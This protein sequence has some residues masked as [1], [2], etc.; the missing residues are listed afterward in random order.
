MSDTQKQP[1]GNTQLPAGIPPPSPAAAAPTSGPGVRT[2]TYT[3]AELADKIRK[4]LAEQVREA[5]EAARPKEPD[6]SKITDR[7]VFNQDVY[8]PAIDHEV[9]DYMN[10]ELKDPEYMVVWA[11]QD[12]RRLGALL[13]TGYELLKEKDVS[14]RFKLP[15]QF[16]SEG[17]YRYMDVIALIVHKRILLGKRRK[18]LQLSLNQLSNRNRPPRVKVKGTF[19]LTEPVAPS[20]GEFYESIV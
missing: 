2:V 5:R 19:D 11:A 15:L 6:W 14:T 13:A 16:D 3:E 4:V 18:S 8:I 9:P 17:L 10:I 12:Q 1:I 7:D 20:V